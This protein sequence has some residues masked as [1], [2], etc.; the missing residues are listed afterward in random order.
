M[1]Y[2]RIRRIGLGLG[3]GLGRVVRICQAIYWHGVKWSLPTRL[4]RCH[5][6]Q[7]P[8]S[9][10]LC[11]KFFWKKNWQTCK[12][13]SQIQLPCLTMHVSSP[14]HNRNPIPNPKPNAFSYRTVS[15]SNGNLLTFRL[16]MVIAFGTTVYRI[17]KKTHTLAP[18]SPTSGGQVWGY[19]YANYHLAY[20]LLYDLTLDARIAL[21]LS[22]RRTLR[23]VYVPVTTNMDRATS[24]VYG[25]AHRVNDLKTQWCTNVQI[26]PMSNRQNNWLKICTEN[27]RIMI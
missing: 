2:I 18:N 15:N 24:K 26:N 5:H 12:R 20:A 21:R 23:I 16:N 8:V 9:A 1:A 13:R 19:V 7:N 27:I 17:A 11:W 14:S 10:T 4:T 25:T 3:I 6:E 22:I